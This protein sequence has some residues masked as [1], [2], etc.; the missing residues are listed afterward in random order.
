MYDISQTVNIKYSQV[1]LGD[2]KDRDDLFVPV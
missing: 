2:Q 1:H